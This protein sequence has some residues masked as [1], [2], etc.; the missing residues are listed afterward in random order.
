MVARASGIVVVED[1]FGAFLVDI[2]NY[3]L[4]LLKLMFFP[5][6]RYAKPR[7]NRSLL[8][9]F[10]RQNKLKN[11]IGYDWVAYLSEKKT[12]VLNPIRWER[13]KTR[14]KATTLVHELAHFFLGRIPGFD[15]ALDYWSYERILRSGHIGG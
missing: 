14:C 7:E 2:V 5:K 9:K 6:V 12:I 11:G 10:L 1:V 4:I 8:R 3:L 15:E 13:W